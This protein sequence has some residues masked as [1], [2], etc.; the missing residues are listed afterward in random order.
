MADKKTN[1]APVTSTLATAAPEGW[2]Q[3][4]TGFPPYWM[5]EEGKTFR[6]KVISVDRE[7]PDFTRFTILA[8]APVTCHRGPKD[9]QTEINVKAG[10][11]FNVSEYV[12][13]PL[14]NYMGFEIW[15]MAK[16]ERPL[17]GGKSTWDF[18]LRVSPETKRLVAERMA[19][20]LAEANAAIP[21]G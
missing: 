12:Q 17:K 4:V 1:P 2:E 10:E 20:L 15:A 16:S 8:T 9:D 3:E 5:P 6:G 18:E 21:S 7:D 14:D 11:L 13:L 19:K